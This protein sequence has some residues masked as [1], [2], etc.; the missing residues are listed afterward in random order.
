M[1]DCCDQRSSIITSNGFDDGNWS[2]ATDHN[3]SA[4]DRNDPAADHNYSATDRD[5]PTANF[6]YSADRPVA[7][8][9]RPYMPH[10]APDATAETGAVGL[11]DRL[12]VPQ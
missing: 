12:L 2:G 7:S 11:V 3:H 8:T 5:D 9:V 1:G 6:N 10:R 4:A